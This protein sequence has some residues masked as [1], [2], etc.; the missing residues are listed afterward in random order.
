MKRL[1]LTC[2]LVLC[3]TTAVAQGP[4]Y[5]AKYKYPVLDRIEARRDSLK[6]LV[7]DAKAAVDA[8]Y[9]GQEKAKKDAA[10]SLRPDWTGVER[11]A[12]P[13]AFKIRLAHLPPVAQYNTGSCWAFSA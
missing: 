1:L 9:A 5:K 2:L 8:Q 12:G 3:A 10:L 11:P 7:A 4:V 6:A 13:D